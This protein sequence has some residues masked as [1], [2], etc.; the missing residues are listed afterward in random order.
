MTTWQPKLLRT[1]SSRLAWYVVRDWEFLRTPAGNMR[2]F[3]SEE[4]AQAAINKT[5]K[6]LSSKSAV[7]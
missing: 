4:A 6:P 2:K 3:R 5:S 1:N 7:I